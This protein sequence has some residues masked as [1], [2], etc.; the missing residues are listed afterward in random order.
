VR[1][2]PVFTPLDFVINVF[3]DQRRQPC[4]HHPTWRARSLYLCPPGTGW[5]SYTPGTGFPFRRFLRL[6]GLRWRY[7]NPPPHW[8]VKVMTMFN[9]VKRHEDT[10]GS[11]CIAPCF[12]NIGT[13]WRWSGQLNAQAGLPLGK[14]PGYPLVG[15]QRWWKRYEKR[16]FSYS[17]RESSPDFSVVQPVA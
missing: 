7:S 16:K 17:C 14:E 13:R 3:T 1:L 11:G 15:S 8:E 2:H 6:A 12:L 9:L 5:P 4:V 10:W